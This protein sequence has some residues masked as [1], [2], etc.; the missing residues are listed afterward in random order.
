[1]YV[2]DGRVLRTGA[3]LAL[4]GAHIFCLAFA[5]LAL[6]GMPRRYLAFLPVMVPAQRVATV[7]VLAGIVGLSLV[8]LRVRPEKEQVA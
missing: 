7:G 8:A 5:R 3:T 2:C 6:L 4:V 1:V